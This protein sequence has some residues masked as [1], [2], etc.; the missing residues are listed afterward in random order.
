MGGARCPGASSPAAYHVPTTWN[1]RHPPGTLALA[2]MATPLHEAQLLLDERPGRH[3]VLRTSTG[4]VAG[5]SAPSPN[6]TGPNQD[7][8]LIAP[9]SGGVV[10]AVADG[11]GGA[12]SGHQASKIAIEQLAE[13]LGAAS[14]ADDARG[15]ILDAFEA[16]N[17]A[18]LALG[19]G[20]AT[21]LAVVELRERLFRPYHAGD[22]S[23]VVCGSRG[24][25]KFTSVPHSPV[26]YGVEAGLIGVEEALHHDEL[27]I[28]SNSLGSSGARIELSTGFM[29]S[30]LDTVL[31]ATDGLF[32][33]L[34]LEEI[35]DIIRVGPLERVA[36]DLEQRATSRMQNERATDPSKPDDLTFVLYRPLRGSQVKLSR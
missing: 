1:S 30:E 9:W 17:T 13:K 36:R 8:A 11:L 21:T 12:P 34:H 20:A 16:A 10:L 7:A 24:K 3:V 4:T 2:N 29:L 22:S 27:N 15:P 25:V 35:V 19:V 31:L 33:N 5:F 28:V 23:I 32:D 14:D 26:G 18:I 6:A